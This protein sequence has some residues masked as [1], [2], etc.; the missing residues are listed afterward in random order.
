MSHSV[1]V[2]IPRLT[3]VICWTRMQTEA[4][5]ELQ[6]IVLRKENERRAGGGLFFWGVGNAP[7]RFASELAFKREDIDVVFSVMKSR[8]KVIDVAPKGILAWQT[9][10]DFRNIECPLPPHVLVTS[11]AHAPSRSKK[12]HYALICTASDELAICNQGPF[13]HTAYNNLGDSG[14]R[15]AP[16]QVTVLAKRT[17]EVSE[18][19]AYQINLRAKLTGSYWIRLGQPIQID[20]KKQALLKVLATRKGLTPFDWIERVS[21]IRHPG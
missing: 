16:S 7:S 3:E 17:R 11:R 10:F 4:G 20:E 6:E 15:I 2:P 19:A 12:M 5:Q 21:Y 8:P 9:F 13:D 14:L 1:Q 18:A